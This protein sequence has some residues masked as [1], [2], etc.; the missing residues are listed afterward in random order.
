MIRFDRVSVARAGVV[1]VRDVELTLEGGHAAAVVGRSGSGRS[2][3]LAA[4]ATAIPTAATC[5]STAI[6]SAPPGP[7]SAA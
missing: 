6:R 3:L 4:V 1:V 2:S 5:S 7:P